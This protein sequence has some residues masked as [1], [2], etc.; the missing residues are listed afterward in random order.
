MRNL[1]LSLLGALALATSG[2]VIA[3]EL[4]IAIVDPQNAIAAT[5]QYTKAVA[6]LEKDTA[7]DKAKLTK[8]QAELNTCSQKMKTDGATMSATDQAKLKSDCEAKYRDY[9]AIGQVFQRTINERQQAI[10]QDIGPKFQRALDA[11]AKE[12]GYDLVLVKE[13]APFAKPMLEITDKV[14][15]KLNTMK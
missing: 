1:T 13:A 14:T 10:L 15:I 12:G 9:Q 4:K 6:D 7:G 5:E 11:V 2:S 8:L 3:A